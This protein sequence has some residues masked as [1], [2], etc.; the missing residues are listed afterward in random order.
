MRAHDA[1]KNTLKPWS[2]TQWVIPPQANA[3]FVRAVEDVLD[4]HA[5]PHDPMLLN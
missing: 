1:Q 2:R 3:E 5:R 4:V